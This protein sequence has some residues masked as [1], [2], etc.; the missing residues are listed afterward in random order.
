VD[1]I[2]PAPG[3][4]LVASPHLRDPNFARSVVLLCEHD[5]DGGSMGLVVN[6][7]SETPL[8][9]A[10]EGVGATSTQR[11]WQ[12]GPVQRDIVIVLHHGLDVEGA[13][14]VSEAMALGGDAGQLLEALRRGSTAVR[15]FAGYSGW[16]V[17]QLRRELE[18]GSWI[19]CPGSAEVVFDT[20]P[21]EMW[22]HLLRSLG[23]RYAYLA[24]LPLDPRVN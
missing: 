17:G 12:G 13:R 10:L 16:G 23:P 9:D 20:T 15:V 19:V 1:T 24:D 6:R 21:T 3:Q 5:D 22:A 8:A 18:E 14:P 11:L 7:P 4:F 2:T